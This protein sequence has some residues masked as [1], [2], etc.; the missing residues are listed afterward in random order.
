MKLLALVAALLLML[1]PGAPAEEDPAQRVLDE[2]GFERF[3]AAND[4]LDGIDVKAVLRRALAGELEWDGDCAKQLLNRFGEAVKAAFSDVIAALAAPVLAAVALRMLLGGQE[5]G[6]GMALLCRMSCAALLMAR[7]VRADGVAQDMLKGASK[8]V[9]AAAPVLASVMALAG[10]GGAAAALSPMAALCMDLIQRALVEI[11]L[12]LCGAAAVLAAAANLSQRFSLNRLFA[13]AKWT[14]ATGLRLL[15]AVFVGVLAVEGLLAP[16]QEQ[17]AARFAQRAIQGALP[18]IG[19]QLSD[20]VGA[21]SVSAAAIQNAVGV[22][23][24]AAVI[25][26][27]A[28]PVLRL[29]A[30][31]LSLKLAAS[32]LEPV[33]DAGVVRMIGHFSELSGMLLAICAE[34]ALLGLLVIG[35]SLGLAAGMGAA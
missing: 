5:A 7:Y 29:A 28:G 4:A 12:P 27:G 6:G 17:L 35:A 15:T 19:G 1:C 31:M 14:V 18:I 3:A 34:A 32:V 33:A 24:L 8:L 20:S 22:T 30:S 23:G 26:A 2:A 9:E 21:L 25:G 10:S 16:G 13:L 11:A